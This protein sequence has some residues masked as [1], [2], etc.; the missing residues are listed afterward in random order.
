VRRSA[1]QL[2]ALPLRHRVR[3]TMRRVDGS[4]WTGDSSICTGE[5]TSVV[6]CE[7]SQVFLVGSD[8]SESFG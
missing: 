2:L 4:P 6:T 3:F 5:G 8:G 1:P 7:H